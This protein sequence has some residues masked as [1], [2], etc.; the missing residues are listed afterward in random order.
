MH[1][2]RTE[3]T[4]FGGETEDLLQEES[5]CRRGHQMH[6]FSKGQSPTDPRC[7]CLILTPSYVMFIPF[8][9]VIQTRILCGNEKGPQLFGVTEKASPELQ[10]KRKQAQQLIPS[11]CCGPFGER[12]EVSLHGKFQSSGEAGE[13]EPTPRNSSWYVQVTGTSLHAAFFLHISPSRPTLSPVHP[14]LL[15]RYITLFRTREQTPLGLSPEDVLQ[16]GGGLLD[17]LT[18]RRHFRG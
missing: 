11:T 7:V 12:P 10:T 3:W 5:G 9:L 18:C 17:L 13:T 16:D 4:P 8:T 2:Q 1:C 15:W 14:T 6:R